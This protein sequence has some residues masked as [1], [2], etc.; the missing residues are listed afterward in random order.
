[1]FLE[2]AAI[3]KGTELTNFGRY[4]RFVFVYGM[5]LHMKRN[6]NQE[7][8]DALQPL[9]ERAYNAIEQG[10][11]KVMRIPGATPMDY[12]MHYLADDKNRDTVNGWFNQ[13]IRDNE[14]YPMDEKDLFKK[15]IFLIKYS[16]NASY[17]DTTMAWLGNMAKAM[18]MKLGNAF[19]TYFAKKK[20]TANAFSGKQTVENIYNELES[21]VKT[22]GKKGTYIAPSELK[23]LQFTNEKQ[24]IAKARYEQ[25]RREL[26]T[27][28]DS[29]VYQILSNGPLKVAVAEKEFRAFG[30]R[31]LPF[32]STAEGYKGMVGLG[33]NGKLAYYTNTGRLLFGAI[34][35][36][37]KV[38]MNSKY[39]ESLDDTYF[40]KFRAP[41]AVSDTLIYSTK[42][43]NVK[44]E[45]KHEKTT[46]NSDKIAT[47]IKAWE[48]DLMNKDPM[49]NVPAAVAMLLYLTSARIGTSKENRSLKGGAHTYGIS[50]LRRQHVKLTSAS[51]ILTYVG[52][53]GMNQRHV[54]KLDDKVTKRIGVIM[55]RLLKDKKKD[56]LVFSFERPT[57]KT[58]AIQEVNPTFFRQYLKSVGVTINPHAIRHI[59]GTELARELLESQT[60]APTPKAKTLAAKQK[61]AETFVKDKVLTKVA[62]L[63]GHKSMKAGV[64]VPAWR[65]SIQSYVKPDLI[66]NWFKGKRLTVPKWV[67]DKLEE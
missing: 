1:M 23:T 54:V 55:G 50:T 46:A 6:G 39:D 28:V 67:P 41:N 58:G 47:W 49:R 60:W 4:A 25:L 7:G 37:S 40:L 42:F 20:G 44:T 22:I 13:Y 11:I 53:K 21:V 12:A 59:R 35:P 3:T 33:S 18:S 26:K 19:V 34:A 32:V 45:A 15:G 57:S 51:I 64:E 16:G 38:T 14:R 9:L 29:T 5:W 66:S 31:D 8:V 62:N 36:S 10:A 43:K 17:A 48:R 27:L 24:V 65:T 30:F 2:Q 61:E 56:D 63:L 52:K